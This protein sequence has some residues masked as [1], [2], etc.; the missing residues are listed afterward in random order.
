MLDV[1]NSDTAVAITIATAQPYNEP[2]DITTKT[3][4]VPRQKWPGIVH[5]KLS[6]KSRYRHQE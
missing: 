3:N 1:S 4:K 6:V 5:T 2:Q